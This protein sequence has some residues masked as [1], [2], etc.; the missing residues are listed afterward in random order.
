M[1]LSVDDKGLSRSRRGS[2]LAGGSD[3]LGQSDDKPGL[4]KQL[5]LGGDGGRKDSRRK[6]MRKKKGK[7]D[8]EWG[9]QNSNYA[10][11]TK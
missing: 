8:E 11:E 7:K 6:S 5:S 10:A 4:S 1:G 2:V 3:M 9:D